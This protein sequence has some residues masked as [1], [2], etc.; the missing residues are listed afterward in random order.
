M[1][2]QYNELRGTSIDTQVNKI[3]HAPHKA[4]LMHLDCNSQ[5]I[6]KLGNIPSKGLHGEHYDPSEKNVWTHFCLSVEAT[7]FRMQGLRFVFVLHPLSEPLNILQSMSL[8]LNF[9]GG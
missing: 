3:G 2:L 4:I 8:T 9:P 7:L 6:T 1:Y 5:N